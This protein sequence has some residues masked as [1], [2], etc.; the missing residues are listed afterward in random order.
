MCWSTVG[1]LV[2]SVE[3]P[4]GRM[5]FEGGASVQWKFPCS[6]RGLVGAADLKSQ[7]EASPQ[8]PGLLACQSQI[9]TARIDINSCCV[10][11]PPS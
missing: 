11:S 1:F 8:E 2:L 4:K 5:Y 9:L 7:V 6:L 10:P 3:V